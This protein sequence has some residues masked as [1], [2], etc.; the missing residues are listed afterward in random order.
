MFPLQTHYL[1]SKPPH[2]ILQPS[3]DYC[4]V[5]TVP[6][7]D[8]V[9]IIHI[10][11]FLESHY[12]YLFFSST[13]IEWNYCTIFSFSQ[14]FIDSIKWRFFFT[15]SN[16]PLSSYYLPFTSCL[17]LFSLHSTSFPSCYSFSTNL[18]QYGDYS[19]LL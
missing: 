10:L 11:L 5:N 16:Y 9:F 17:L 6:T 3:I 14:S 18:P 15:T 8:E 12:H 4:H 2:D 19:S 1:L 13:S 7:E